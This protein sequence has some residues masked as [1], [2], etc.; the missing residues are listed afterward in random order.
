MRLSGG[1]PL[2]GWSEYIRAL[3]LRTISACLRDLVLPVSI[4]RFREWYLSQPDVKERYGTA[5]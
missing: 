1:G 2:R 4:R 5:D 3:G